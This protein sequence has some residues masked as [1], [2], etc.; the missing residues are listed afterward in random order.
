MGTIYCKKC[1]VNLSYYKTDTYNRLGEHSYY[2]CRVHNY[3]NNKCKDCCKSSSSNC[4][5]LWVNYI[6]DKLDI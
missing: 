3:E 6:Q 5:H 2:S 1:G 4:K